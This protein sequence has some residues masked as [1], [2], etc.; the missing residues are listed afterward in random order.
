MVHTPSPAGIQQLDDSVPSCVPTED[1][2]K[3]PELTPL[4]RLATG[5][6]CHKAL[7][8]LLLKPLVETKQDLLLTAQK[9]PGLPGV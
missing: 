7:H 4:C 2:G 8:V 5:C 6:V 1:L 3:A 9:M